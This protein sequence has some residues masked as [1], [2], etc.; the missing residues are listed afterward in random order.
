MKRAKVAL[1]NKKILPFVLMVVLSAM[2]TTP[3]TALASIDPPQK[4]AAEIATMCPYSAVVASTPDTAMYNDTEPGANDPQVKQGF[5]AYRAASFQDAYNKWL[6]LAVAGN[7]TAQYYLSSFFVGEDADDQATQCAIQWLQA[8]AAHKHVGANAGLGRLLGIGDHD[9]ID[10]PQAKSAL[11]F[12]A[13]RCHL[14]AQFQLG[15]LYGRIPA[16]HR[17]FVEAHKWLM[18]AS[19]RGLEEAEDTNKILRRFTSVAELREGNRRH[20]EWLKNNP[21]K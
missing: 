9:F 20:K 21:C 19:T 4:S 8:A 1:M 10:L 15:S 16:P 3:F 11:L 5:D 12:A 14:D 2:M 13:E 17:D 7:A 18:V 6:P